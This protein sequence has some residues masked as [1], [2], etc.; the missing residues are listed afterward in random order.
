MIKVTQRIPTDPYAYIEYEKEYETMS[1][2]IKEHRVLCRKV[3]LGLP[4]KEWVEVRRTIF[5]TGEF[6]PELWNKLNSEQQF[7]INEFKKE[8]RYAESTIN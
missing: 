4:E 2:A 6:N 5:N 3:G 8:K 7:L 1:E